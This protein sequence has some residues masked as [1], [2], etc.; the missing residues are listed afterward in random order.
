MK[1]DFMHKLK[2]LISPDYLVTF[3]DELLAVIFDGHAF[4]QMLPPADS[5]FPQKFLDIDLQFWSNFMS[6]S[7][8]IQIHIVFD[9]YSDSSMKGNTRQQR[10]KGK[11]S[12]E[13]QIR[14]TTRFP[15]N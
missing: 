13:F 2:N 10:T 12:H 3:Q 4:I 6:S 9:R 14:G 5:I 11:A 8:A 15:R 1:S 7:V